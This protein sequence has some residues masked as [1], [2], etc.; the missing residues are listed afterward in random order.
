MGFLLRILKETGLLSR[1]I[2]LYKELN[3]KYDVKFT[4]FTYGNS[5]DIEIAKEF[6][7]INVIPA[8]SYISLSKSKIINLLKTLYLP[9]KS[10][11]RI[12]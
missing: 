3:K 12:K 6:S 2:A 9:F 1:E 5:E 10:K 11:K 7:F 4:F 8:N